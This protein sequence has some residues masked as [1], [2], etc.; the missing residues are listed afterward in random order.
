MSHYHKNK[1]NHSN[2]QL[3]FFLSSNIIGVIFIMELFAWLEKI[4]FAYTLS[5]I[6]YEIF[7]NANST[8]EPVFALTSINSIL[9]PGYENF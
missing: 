6:C 4:S 7:I 3:H 2:Q 5:F 1:V 8:F 9:L